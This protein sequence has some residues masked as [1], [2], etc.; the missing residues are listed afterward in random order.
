MQRQY[1]LRESD[2]IPYEKALEALSGIKQSLMKNIAWNTAVIPTEEEIAAFRHI[3]LEDN[4]GQKRKS[5]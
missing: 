4:P 3:R 2:R 5:R 1:V